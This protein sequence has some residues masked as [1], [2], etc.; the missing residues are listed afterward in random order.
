MYDHGNSVVSYRIVSY[1]CTTMVSQHLHGTGS[2]W[3]RYEIGVDKATQ[4]LVDRYESDLLSG[5]RADQKTG[6]EL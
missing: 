6:G 4:D 2:V 3:N 5:T 1:L